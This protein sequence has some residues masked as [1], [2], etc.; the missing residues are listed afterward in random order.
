MSFVG[1]PRLSQDIV[2][3]RLRNDFKTTKNVE[4]APLLNKNTIISAVKTPPLSFMH[5]IDD[6]NIHHDVYV[7]R[8]FD[9]KINSLRAKI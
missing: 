3:D 8:C 4:P 2:D 1:N 9:V 6:N 5:R 7:P